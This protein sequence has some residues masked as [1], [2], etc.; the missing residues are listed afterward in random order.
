M[1]KITLFIIAVALISTA[2][3][4]S[5]W[6]INLEE[7]PAIAIAIQSG[8]LTAG[9]PGT[10]TFLVATLNINNTLTGSV[11][12]YSDVDGTVAADAPAGVSTSLSTGDDIR[13]L[14]VNTT[15]ASQQGVYYFRVTIDDTQSI[16]PGELTIDAAPVKTVSVG[17]QSG[18]L[19]AGTAGNVT[20]PVT[21]AN[22]PNG[23]YTAT[24]TN[25]PTGVSVSGQ[26]TI[27]NNSGT[28]TL[29]G[30]AQTVASATST[31]RL[32]IDNTQ[33]AAFTLTIVAAPVKTVTVDRQA[34][35]ITA[36]TPGSVTFPVATANIANSEQGSIQWYSNA[37]GTASANT[38]SGVISTSESTGS[39]NRT[40]TINTG[41]DTGA[42]TY[43]FRVTI[44]GVQSNVGTFT[45][46]E[47][48]E[49]TVTVDKQVGTL[50]AGRPG[51]VTFPVTTANIA[52][53]E[54]GS[55]RWYTDASGRAP[56]NGP[57]A[58]ISA[59]V[60]TGSANRTLTVTMGADTGVQT[61]YFRVT[62]DSV[63]S[64]VQILSIQQ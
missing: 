20:F 31:L 56:A 42:G 6:E 15:S 33:S 3:V 12:W 48:P 29:A 22:I 58:L 46:D 4:T 7:D 13:T 27:N 41:Q 44:N 59:S 30:N 21:T 38:P 62:I 36:G 61:H 63:E 16:N 35:T 26:V 54:Q 2:F 28:L 5:C 45:I 52:F 64:N 60:T 43:Y 40:L 50:T 24:V 47:V 8:T 39:A 1:K 57:G 23:S 9:T 34:G 51:S 11:Q 55:V 37:N 49:K 18:T 10:A 17:T 25:L 32:T 14:T 19:T 53:T